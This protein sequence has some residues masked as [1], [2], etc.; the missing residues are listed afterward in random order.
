MVKRNSAQRHYL[1]GN[2]L[3]PDTQQASTSRLGAY[4]IPHP[5]STSSTLTPM[6][7]SDIVG[8]GVA[9]GAVV[10]DAAL[11]LLAGGATSSHSRVAAKRRRTNG[12]AGQGSHRFSRHPSDS[13]HQ[14]DDGQDDGASFSPS[15]SLSL[16]SLA[17]THALKSSHVQS[18]AHLPADILLR[19]ADLLQPIL[20]PFRADGDT[21]GLTVSGDGDGGPSLSSQWIDPGT[22]VINLRSTCRAIYLAVE[23]LR[24]TVSGV[25]LQQGEHPGGVR[26]L[27]NFPLGK[28]AID[29]SGDGSELLIARTRHLWIHST[30]PR[31]ATDSSIFAAS[32]ICA[33]IEGMPRLRTFALV[34][35]TE[36]EVV[37]G[38]PYTALP[39]HRNIFYS[40]SRL[41]R[42]HSLYF[43]GVKLQARA[44]VFPHVTTLVLNACHDCPLE[45]ISTCPKL[46]I[47]KAWRDFASRA[48]LEMAG[49]WW[50]EQRWMTVKHAELR[51]FSGVTGSAFRLS[52][53]RNLM[54]LRALSTPP[55]I[56]LISLRLCEA[57]DYTDLCHLILPAIAHLPHLTSFTCMVWKDRN[58]S[59]TLLGRIAGDL[60]NLVHLGLLLENEGT[61]WW[62]GDMGN[63]GHE[64]MRF[65]KLETFTWNF[66]AYVGLDWAATRETSL[67][68]I[69]SLLCHVGPKFKSLHWLQQSEYVLRSSR[70]SKWVWSDDV[71]ERRLLE[72]G[73]I[74]DDVD[75]VGHGGNSRDGKENRVDDGTAGVGVGVPKRKRGI[76]GTARK[77]LFDVASKGIVGGGGGRRRAPSQWAL[78]IDWEQD[79]EGSS[80]ADPDS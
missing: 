75:A 21:D 48:Q 10:A 12:Q 5:R 37:F 41:E 17:T 28:G 73:G 51:G 47:V 9:G 42:L 61:N 52:W 54:T 77:K 4:S 56:P 63:Y 58:F 30:L 31:N 15:S 3:A 44:P 39:L 25:R 34:Q 71:I 46:E 19:I 53:L 6:P 27:T 22:D 80:D 70:T 23:P 65:K 78:G 67:S 76:G 33:L 57:Y 79:E 59:P 36:D 7:S 1:I 40:L 29:P 11:Q 16:R 43:C 66:T 62:P 2:G 45:L 49:K 24:G 69:Q 26:V 55:V 14:D 18:L 32:T 8:L 13:L 20:S 38:S 35:A 68:V 64:L 74:L 50:P 60:P 72:E